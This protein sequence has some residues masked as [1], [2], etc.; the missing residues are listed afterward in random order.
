MLHNC[1]K[2]TLPAVVLFWCFCPPASGFG[3]YRRGISGFIELKCF[4][5]DQHCQLSPGLFPVV[6]A[7]LWPCSKAVA[8]LTTSKSHKGDSSP[9]AVWNAKTSSPPRV[10]CAW[11]KAR[12]S[13]RVIPRKVVRLQ[14]ACPLPVLSPHSWRLLGLLPEG[15]VAAGF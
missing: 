10:Y 14:V 11:C 8:W 3:T 9:A 4:W 13:L 15:T 1:K 7:V 5:I 6:T 12:E 2:L